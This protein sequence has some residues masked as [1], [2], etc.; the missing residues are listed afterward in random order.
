MCEIIFDLSDDKKDYRG[1]LFANV[2]KKQIEQ[3]DNVKIEESENAQVTALI[4]INP[5]KSWEM[6]GCLKYE[7]GETQILEGK[8]DEAVN[9]TY[10]LTAIY[11]IPLTNK[12][13]HRNP[14][15]TAKGIRR[16]I[17]EENFPETLEE[18]I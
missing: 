15:G 13:W 12:R 18:M 5:D 9:E 8:F 14:C 2:D 4:W 16:I 17:D 6:K 11:N 1:I 7:D 3:E 10:I